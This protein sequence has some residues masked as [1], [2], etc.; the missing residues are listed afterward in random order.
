MGHHKILLV[1]D[2]SIEAMDIKR[3][4]ESFGYQVPYVASSGEKAIDKVLEIKP[5]L[6]L[7]DIILKGAIDGI[8]TISKIKKLDIPVIYLTAHSEESTIERAK[9]TEPAGYIIKPYDSTELKYAIELAIY[10]NEMDKKLK[11]SEKEYRK[12]YNSMNEGLAVHEL[13]YNQEKVPVDYKIV[14]INAAFEKVLGIKKEDVVGKKATAAYKTEEAPYLDIYARVAETGTPTKFETYFQPMD[15][16]FTISV[17]S[18]SPGVFATVFEDIT[19]EKRVKKEL[20]KSEEKYRTI[21][22]N[23]ADAILLTGPNGQIYAANPAACQMFGRTEKE[24]VQGGRELVVDTTDPRLPLAIDERERTGIFKGELTFLR[25]NGEPFTGELTSELFE[26][27]DGQIRS[28]MI[29]RDVTEH[30]KLENNLIEGKTK[31]KA[32]IES[33]NDAVFVS[34][35]EGNFIDFN[36]AFA[37]YHKFKNKEEVYKRMDEFTET[38]DVYFDETKLAPLDMWAVP[39]ALRGEKVSNEEY[40]IQRKDT[41]EKWWG[42]Y[43]FAPIKDKN[44]K[45]NGSVVVA[46]DVTSSKKAEKQLR[47]VQERLNMGMNIANLAY[48]EYDVKNDMFTFNDQ[49][50]KLYSTSSQKEG[51]YQMSS[52]KYANR[53]IPPEEAVLVEEEIVKA[54]ETDDPQYSSTI[55]HTII[56]VDGEKR[57]MLVR[58]LVVK[59]ENGQTIKTRGVNQD[60]TELKVTEKNLAISE[61]RYRAVFENSGTPLLTFDD[62]GIILMINSEWERMSGYSQEEVIGKMKWMDFVHPDY[63][64]MMMKYHQQRLIEPDSVPT[65]Y[66]SVFINKNGTTLTMYIAISPLPGTKNWLASALDITDLKQTQKSLEKNVLRFRALAEYAI[67]GI[68]TT[69]AHG[70]ILYFNKSLMEIFDYNPEELESAKITLL[71]P[72]RYKETFLDTLNKFRITGE[73]RLAGRTI[74]TLGL[75]KGGNEFPFEMSLTKWE[76]EEEIYFTS[77]IRDISERKEAEKALK[78]SE[79][80]YRALFDNASDGIFLMENGRFVECNE[81]ALE[82]YGVTRDQ[83]IG[84]T[85][86]DFSPIKQPDGQKSEDKAIKLINQALQGNPQH[87]EWTHLQS[88]GNSFYAEVSLNRLEIKGKYLIQAIVRDVTERKEA[89]EKLKES[90]E[91]INGIF[92]TVMSGILLFDHQGYIKFVN[93]HVTTL[94]GYEPSELTKMHYL[95]LV[96]PEEKDVAKKSLQRFIKGDIEVNLERLYQ[97][98]DGSIFWGH[99]SAKRILNEDG[100][101]KGLIGSITDISELKKA[102]DDLIDSLNEKE[103]LLKEIHHRVKNN[104]QIISSLLNLES[105]EVKD[106]ELAINILKESQ[107]RVKSMAMIHEKLYQSEDLTRI[108]ISDYIHRLV[109]DLYYSYLMSTKQVTLVIDVEDLRLNI[110]TAVPCG[111]IIS[112][113]VSN[114]LKYAFTNGRKGEIKISLKAGQEFNE[115]IISDDGIGF[116]EE[117]DFENPETL[118]L[119]LVNN[120]INQIDGEITLDKSKGTSFKI[121]FKELEYKERL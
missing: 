84:L 97:N 74:E 78:I 33:M 20:E 120:L 13:I 112:E 70:N 76:I 110:E 23:S 83:I 102:K 42:S 16:Y 24:I 100:S 60:I 54:M 67:D 116:P 30:K 80:K 104:M 52:Q 93:K 26:D 2:E 11:I 81:K 85:P 108:N 121:R 48:W 115:L 101:L 113:L 21:F 64:K 44:G 3:T 58:F 25:R 99:L 71:M 92:N 53:F 89:E 65:K 38:F 47:S 109:A 117:I 91:Q 36:E 9:L 29:I 96:S 107:N 28:S 46:R 68:I 62:N 57:I 39:R 103:V 51:G 34:D 17:F 82:I 55:Q 49:F 69:D 111:L 90:R 19:V 66:E 6:I 32:V 75:K 22:E 12:L 118:G 59:D 79:E 119:Q 94:F 45:I 86:I 15:K 50:Y 41:G 7:M 105:K 37:T 72:E 87:F 63:K 98:K 114:S 56:R 43:S 1:E 77:I 40:L 18:P 95:E 73:H 35:A 8:E 88:T 31:L 10:K 14:N 61:S 106:D 4:L 5:D 27:S